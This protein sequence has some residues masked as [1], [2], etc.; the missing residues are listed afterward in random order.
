MFRT[1]GL[2]MPHPRVGLAETH[3]GRG[4]S[5]IYPCEQWHH[6][7]AMQVS[8]QMHLFNHRN[9]VQE[10]VQPMGRERQI[11]IQ[12]NVVSPIPPHSMQ[13]SMSK[14]PPKLLMQCSGCDVLI[15]K[16]SVA[17]PRPRASRGGSPARFGP[18]SDASACWSARPS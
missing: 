10:Y 14:K 11:Y 2:Q 6:S 12:R 18:Q 5:W 17:P 16:L 3:W 15:S 9:Y 13:I 4:S 1:S 7:K 8:R